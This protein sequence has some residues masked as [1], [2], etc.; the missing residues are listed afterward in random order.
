M[1]HAAFSLAVIVALGRGSLLAGDTQPPA[2]PWKHLD[3]KTLVFVANGAGGA[4]TI[5]DLL[6]SASR[7]QGFPLLVQ[8]VAWS[9][10]Q[11]PRRDHLD[12]DAH[13]A[14]ASYIAAWVQVLHRDCPNLRIYLVGYSA[15]A[16]VVLSAARGCPPGSIQGIILLAPSVS[17]SYDLRPALMA[18]C[19]GIDS[20]YSRLDDVLGYAEQRLGTADGCWGPIAGRVGFSPVGGP[21][22]L[23]AYGS[24]R[25]H[26]WR[27]G[28]GGQGGHGSWTREQFLYQTL[29]PLLL[30]M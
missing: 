24:L 25:Q 17:C 10:F 27:D 8:P 30:G 14:A 15:G 16:H 22:E 5:S 9:R 1:R 2:A 13:H 7:R 12:Q 26:P 18:S 29:L 21:A 6:L 20:F 3:G 11:E 19:G 23:A 28:M 4:M